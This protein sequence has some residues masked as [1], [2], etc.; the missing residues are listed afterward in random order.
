MIGTVIFAMML[1]L[2]V[3]GQ[4]LPFLSLEQLSEH[5]YA[6]EEAT[7]SALFNDY[8]WQEVFVRSKEFMQCTTLYHSRTSLSKGYY[9]S[10][11]LMSNS[12][13]NLPNSIIGFGEL[14]SCF[15]DQPQATQSEMFR[16]AFKKD[17]IV[18]LGQLYFIS[19]KFLYPL[20]EKQMHEL[21]LKVC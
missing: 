14:R 2:P 1:L 17:F 6:I 16:I 5:A 9:D 19:P 15:C 18:Q 3:Q 21:E 20:V 11:R 13:L 7:G 10:R 4:P 12:D 8:S